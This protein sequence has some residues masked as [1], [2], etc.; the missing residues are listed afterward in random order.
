MTAAGAEGFQLL[1]LSVGDQGTGGTRTDGGN[2]DG[3]DGGDS[4]SMVLL[5]VRGDGRVSIDGGGGVIVKDGDLEVSQ[6]DATFKVLRGR[7]H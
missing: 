2:D 5:S 3:G 1:E 7:E 6:G 4:Q